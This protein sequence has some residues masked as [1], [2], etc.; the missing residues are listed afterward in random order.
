MIC[1]R[2]YC[3]GPSFSIARRLSYFLV[4]V[5]LPSSLIS[6]RLLSFKRWPKLVAE[7]LKS[8]VART[9]F[10]L[11][12]KSAATSQHLSSFLGRIKG[13]NCERLRRISWLAREIYVLIDLDR[14]FC[15]C[16]KMLLFEM[17]FSA[18]IS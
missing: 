1:N 8:T 12:G 9:E 18:R 3:E 16:T 13:S 15:V 11:A 2:C 10:I 5:R 4:R 14:C 17:L 6:S 7:V